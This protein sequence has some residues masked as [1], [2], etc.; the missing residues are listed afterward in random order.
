M[1]NTFNLIL[2]VIT[3]IM[4]SSCN[5]KIESSQN[6][7]KNAVL[8]Y[9]EVSA[10]DN[11]VCSFELNHE[12]L[13]RV[14]INPAYSA[15]NQCVL[16]FLEKQIAKLTSSLDSNNA[17]TLKS[18]NLIFEGCSAD[19]LN[20]CLYFQKLK[21]I[22]AMRDFLL[23]L[24]TVH[25]SNIQKYYF[26]L[27][28]WFEL[29]NEQL[30]A[31]LFELYLKKEKEYRKL[32]AH[33]KTLLDLHNE[34]LHL[35]S[36][37]ASQLSNNSAF[38]AFILSYKLPTHKNI[39][40]LDKIVL[41][42]IFSNS[43]DRDYKSKLETFINNEITSIK[44]IDN[45]K[46]ADLDYYLKS[47]DISSLQ[48]D[49]YYYMIASAYHNRSD[50]NFLET[51]WKFYQ[52]DTQKLSDTTNSYVRI[53]FL[54]VLSL[55]H[56]NIVKYFHEKD[57]TPNNFFI[58]AISKSE[59][60][61]PHFQELFQKSE[62]LQLFLE[63]LL[64]KG[65]SK[66]QAIYQDLSRNLFS[67][68]KMNIKYMISFPEMMILLYEFAKNG[69][70]FKINSHYNGLVQVSS[71]QIMKEFFEGRFYSFFNYSDDTK[72]LTSEEILY[73]FYFALNTGLFRDFASKQNETQLVKDFIKMVATQLSN[74]EINKLTTDFNVF[75]NN[76]KA[77]TTYNIFLNLCNSPKGYVHQLTLDDLDRSVLQGKIV[78]ERIVNNPGFYGPYFERSLER[79]R[80]NVQNIEFKVTQMISIYEKYL[81]KF[82]TNE[83]V[84]KE[85]MADLNSA[86]DPITH[87]KTAYL[88][89]F[90]KRHQE[91]DKCHFSI[92]QKEKK[93]QE[94]LI[95]Y[96][97]L[98]LRNLYNKYQEA[99]ATNSLEELNREIQNYNLKDFIGLNKF[100]NGHY[101]YTQID[102]LIR[103]KQFIEVGQTLDNQKL[104]A[105]SKGVKISVP[106]NEYNWIQHSFYAGSQDKYFTLDISNMTEDEFVLNALSNIVTDTT[107]PNGF[108]TWFV[109]KSYYTY[110]LPSFNAKSRTL[111]SLYKLGDFDIYE[112]EECSL[113]NSG[114]GCKRIK[115][116]FSVDNLVKIGSNLKNFLHIDDQEA[117]ILKKVGRKKRI[118]DYLQA[119][120][121]M[122]PM[123]NRPENWG[124]FDYLYYS[125]KEPL[126]DAYSKFPW[127]MEDD[128][129]SKTLDKRK[130]ALET[131]FDYWQARNNRGEFL[132][133][134]SNSFEAEM[135]QKFKEIA[136]NEINKIRSFEA[137]IN[138]ENNPAIEKLQGQ[139]RY[140][141]D[142]T[143]DK[144]I[145]SDTLLEEVDGVIRNFH[146]QTNYFYKQ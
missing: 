31:R 49:F 135:N 29:K 123:S 104:P 106:T 3:M 17:D 48:Y 125:L 30:D 116:K 107:N 36:Q 124:I 115:Q 100:K 126:L 133:N 78:G 140:E 21:S 43:Q 92:Y 95:K 65:N 121:F 28:A 83:T 42:I 58:K 114:K 141:I 70:E 52:G 71:N 66:S 51:L 91:I 18:M 47:L 77:D 37:N 128:H 19:S 72:A 25:E 146:Q 38:K 99:Y 88:T 7:H 59:Q 93:L 63:S 1:K 50:S 108:V 44:A 142:K 143:V 119:F 112:K 35:I 41:E 5:K 79:I 139:I 89:Q 27:N 64:M 94:N 8:N 54:Q 60:V 61:S 82:N 6:Q 56:Q 39:S 137:A 15:H 85:I 33:D 144:D 101:Y 73:A 113:K 98:Y 87:I 96:E 20:G 81:R 46:Q 40:N 53:K 103:A 10:I 102:F 14:L 4:I 145:L 120:S 105:L 23:K 127:D 67:G 26:F 109:D 24:A 138:P 55:S 131:A 80:T 34:T 74:I 69:L 76:Y 32:I 136:W 12:K 117:L 13:E 75:T 57:Y 45:F 90:M 2:L 97:E 118:D 62:Y 130:G 129:V 11:S 110:N 132:F 86:L 134:I 122:H 22:L 16:K 68:I 111:V 84:V 9:S